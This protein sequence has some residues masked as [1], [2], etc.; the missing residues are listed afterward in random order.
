MAD[1]GSTIY[2]K[3]F[4]LGSDKDWYHGELNPIEAERALIASGDGDGC[5]LIRQ[6]NKALFLSLI[7]QGQV[8]HIGIKYGPGWYELD[9]GTAQY[10]FI[11][12]EELVSHY[13]SEVISD[14]LNVTLAAVC[15][16]RARD[17]DSG[18]HLLQIKITRIEFYS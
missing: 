18:T 8:H 17:E 6:N 10:S 11:E 1:G 9:G 14:T 4:L 3:G 2:A 7:H 13:Q 15:I 16:K 12:L 5:F